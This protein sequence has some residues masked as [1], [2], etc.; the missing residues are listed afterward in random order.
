MFGLWESL[1]VTATGSASSSLSFGVYCGN[2]VG[3]MMCNGV[4]T[5]DILYNYNYL[6]KK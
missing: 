6:L 1:T 4:G 2:G 3:F 5:T